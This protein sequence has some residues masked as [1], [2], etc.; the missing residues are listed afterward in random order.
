MRIRS[1]ALTAIAAAWIASVPAG[2]SEYVMRVHG[3]PLD[4][5][6][7]LRVVAPGRS[8][9]S[10]IPEEIALDLDGDGVDDLWVTLLSSVTTTPLTGFE[11]ATSLRITGRTGVAVGVSGPMQPGEAINRGDQYYRSVAL[12]RY[13]GNARTE[14][15]FGSWVRGPDEMTGIL[16]VRLIGEDGVHLGYLALALDGYGNLSRLSHALSMEPLA[17]LDIPENAMDMAPAALPAGEDA[18]PMGDDAPPPVP[19]MLRIALN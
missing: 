1:L 7:V 4:E 18:A 9:H 8:L 10:D 12:A 16:P 14:F 19:D 6:T 3:N 11:T 2:A 15:F 13:Q 5:P 17:R